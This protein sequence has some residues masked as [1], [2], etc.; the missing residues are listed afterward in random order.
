MAKTIQS[1]LN[2]TGG[3]FKL[4]D[5]MI[6][7]FPENIDT[8][9]DLF[10]GG[11]NVSIN[12]KAKK[13]YYNDILKEVA[14]FV[15]YCNDVDAC[16]L[17]ETLDAYINEYGLSK[18]NKEAYYRLR[19]DYNKDKT[20]HVKF[21]LLVAHSFNN[22]IRFNKKGEYNMPF[23]KNRSSFNPRLRQ[24]LIEFINRLEKV[25]LV[26]TSKDF[27]EFR[28]TEFQPTDLVY[29]DPP[30]LISTA[31]YNEGGGWKEADER[32]L[33][34]FLDSIDR[35]GSRFALSNVLCHNGQNNKLLNVWSKN[36]RVSLLNHSYK[37]CNY[38][39]KDIGSSQEVLITN[40]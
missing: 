34:S 33:Y 22:Q 15:E 27:R 6:P 35:G 23:G 18:T 9:Y 11:G 36:Y 20:S 29:C 26:V 8:F 14:C 32:D 24:K 25:N 16:S 2:Y 38:Q 21:F 31:T 13:I 17:L 40:Y 19:E 4:L 12:V 7:L 1:P 30:Y 3:K 39:R 37:N 10:G 28:N 5:Q